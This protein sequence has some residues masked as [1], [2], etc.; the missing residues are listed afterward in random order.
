MVK[1]TEVQQE[2]DMF[3]DVWKLYKALLPV[4]SKDDEV[5]WNTVVNGISEIMRKYP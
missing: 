5:Y 4:R 3:A 1:N 2:F